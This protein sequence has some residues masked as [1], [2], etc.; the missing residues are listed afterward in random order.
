LNIL[1]IDPPFD[2]YL[3]GRIYS[4]MLGISREFFG[5]VKISAFPGGIAAAVPVSTWD[6]TAC[7][8]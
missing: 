3:A 7:P 2:S 8:L 1:I 5:G 4:P 6:L